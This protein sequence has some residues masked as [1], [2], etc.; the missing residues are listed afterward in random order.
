MDK[1][2]P[3]RK[4]VIAPSD[5]PWHG[6]VYRTNQGNERRDYRNLT[7][8]INALTHLTGWP[9]PADTDS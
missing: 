2:T 6:S 4:L 9:R 5:T 7:E 1:R 3:S 8:L